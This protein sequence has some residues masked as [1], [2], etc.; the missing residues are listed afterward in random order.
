MNDTKEKWQNDRVQKKQNYEV[1][2]GK[3]ASKN[4]QR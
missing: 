4:S 1:D 3:K 2:N